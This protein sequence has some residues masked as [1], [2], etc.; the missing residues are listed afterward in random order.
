MEE[1]SLIV[2]KAENNVI[3]KENKLLWHLPADM[4]FFKTMTTGQIIIMGH[5]T[6]LALGKALPNRFNIVITRDPNRK[7]E[8]CIVVNSIEKALKIA[9]EKNISNKNIEQPLQKIMIIGGEQIYKLALPLVNRL[10]I[11]E[12][13]ANFDGDTFFPSV[14]KTQWQEVNRELYL[15]DEKNNINFD[16]VIFDRINN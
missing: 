6:Y 12:I 8:G 13:K 15:A 3:G 4:K 10:Y 1:I 2:A 11:T 9:K 16:F 5:N 7:I 14:D